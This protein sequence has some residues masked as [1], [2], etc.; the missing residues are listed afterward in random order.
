MSYQEIL[1]QESD[2]VGVIT[3]NRPD[4]LNAFTTHTLSE[5]RHA[6]N[7][8]SADRRVVG[9]VVTGTGRAFSA[10]ADVG[11]FT[12]DRVDGDPSPREAADAAAFP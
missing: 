2:D 10:G 7:A 11:A 9:I 5:I 6:I 1:Y 3:L 12:A 8:A 4:Q